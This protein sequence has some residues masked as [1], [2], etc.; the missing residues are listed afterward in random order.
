VCKRPR[1]RPP[2]L[3]SLGDVGLLCGLGSAARSRAGRRLGREVEKEG[4]SD[5]LSCCSV[6][7]SPMTALAIVGFP[8]LALLYFTGPRNPL[9]TR[10]K[11]T[12]RRGNTQGPEGGKRAAGA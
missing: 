2:E 11:F 5:N 7:C 12:E 8:F 4:D 6:I 10:P 1:Y 9:P 3:C